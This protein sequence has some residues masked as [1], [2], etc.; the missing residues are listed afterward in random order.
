MRRVQI[1]CAMGKAGL[2]HYAPCFVRLTALC[3]HLDVYGESITDTQLYCIA[4]ETV[5]TGVCNYYCAL[6]FNGDAFAFSA[7]ILCPLLSNS[8]RN[9]CKNGGERSRSVTETRKD[10]FLRLGSYRTHSTFDVV[11]SVAR[12]KSRTT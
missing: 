1:I 10:I 11:W 7:S 12:R 8:Q 5:L 2:L 6:S 3:A 9:N 4:N